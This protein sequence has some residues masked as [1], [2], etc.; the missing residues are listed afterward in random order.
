MQEVHDHA[1]HFGSKI[2]LE[3]LRFRVYW[4]KMAA[5][6]REYIRG[7]LPYAKW[8]TLARS[9][10][11]TPI[12][13]GKPYELME[14]D[15]ISPFEKFAYGNTYIYNLVDYFSRHMYPHPTFKAGT[16]DVIIL[17]DHYLQAHPK[18]YAIYMDAGSH[19]ISQKLR[20]SFQK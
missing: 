12:Q 9:V 3:R 4:P 10:P 20:R 16:N 15:F 17:F 8:A 6:V 1:G 14:I 5:D 18:P 7:C 13:T 19:F 2:V 11:L